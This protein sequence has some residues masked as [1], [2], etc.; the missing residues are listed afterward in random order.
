MKF[1]LCKKCPYSELFW[2]VYSRIPNENWEIL[3]ISLH[4]VRMRENADQNNSEYRHLLQSVERHYSE[5]LNQN[6]LSLRVRGERHPYQSCHEKRHLEV[7]AWVGF[8]AILSVA[9]WYFLKSQVNRLF[10]ML[11][12][13]TWTRFKINFSVFYFVSLLFL[14][15]AVMCLFS[16]FHISRFRNA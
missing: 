16:I 15:I 13:L 8:L 4:S 14:N 9:I 11:L 2:S 5:I 7:C 12:K 3:R 10:F 6:A 1:T